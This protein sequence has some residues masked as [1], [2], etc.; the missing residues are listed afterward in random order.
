MKII[1]LIIDETDEQSGIEAISLVEQPAIES[2]F[3]AL[4]KH[5]IL[6]KEIDTDKRILMGPALIPDKSIYRRNDQGDEYYIYFSQNTVRKASE[7]FFKKSNHRNATFEHKDRI[8]GVTFVES[9]IVENKD[10]DKTA[11]YG[12]DVPVGTWMVSAK[13]DDEELYKKAKAGEVKGFSIEGYFADR[14]EMSKSND[15]KEEIVEALRD[16]LEVKAASYSDYPDAVSNNAKRGIE[17]NKKNNN[18]CA[19]Q[20]GKVR[21]RQLANKEPISEAT[22]KRMF[23]YLS[24][25]ETY[26]E[27]GDTNDCGYISYLLWGGKAG[28][29]W[30]ESKLKQ[31]EKLAEV[32]PRGGVKRSK[33]APKSDTPNKNPKGKGSAKGDAST[34]RGAVVS[35][36]DEE[37]LKKK[38]TEFNERYKDKLGYGANVGSLKTVFQRGLGAFNTS[39]SPKVKSAKQWAMAR[40]NA[41]LYLL[42]NGRPQN[43]KYTGDYD[44][45]PAKHP[46]S[47]K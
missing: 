3:V 44:L 27:K 13:I 29:R 38:S 7:L 40:V 46:K 20:V 21:A 17:L 37:S 18:K 22:I 6:L 35:K 11:L 47:N 14:Y 16:L 41:F 19:T 30:A 2:N 23:S 9:W 24:R 43:P 32:G 42:K 26:Y 31:I 5:E 25:A 34:S 10:K 28:K 1:E 8:N 33:K 45:L 39:H 15:A 12:M 4:N 36:A